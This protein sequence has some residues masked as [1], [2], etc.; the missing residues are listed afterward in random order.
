M[1]DE[2][3]EQGRIPS[4]LTDWVGQHGAPPDAGRD[5][6]PR[7]A[8]YARRS[9]ADPS[10]VSI[11]RQ[12]SAGLDHCRQI[13][14]SIDAEHH[15]YIDRNRSGRTT[16]GRLSLHALL[17]A[18]RDR[19]FD[20]LVVQGLERLTRSMADAV[21]IQAELE[22]LGIAIHVPG[23]GPISAGE[24]LLS[25]FQHQKELDALVERINDGRRRTARSGSMI[26]RRVPYGYDRL[27]DGSGLIVNTEQAS[28]IR[29]CFE[30]IDGGVSRC[31][32]VRTLKAEF[33]L[34]P[35]GRPWQLEQFYKPDGYGRLQDPI[36]KG[37]WTW[38]RGSSNSVTVEV[39]HL[40]IVDAELFDRVNAKLRASGAKSWRTGIKAGLL[41]GLVRCMCGRPMVQ[42]RNRIACS[43]SPHMDRCTAGTAIPLIDAERQYY[44]FLLDEVLD[45][46]HFAD[47][48]AVRAAN[49]SEMQQAAACESSRMKGRL[50]EIT[51]E[52]NAFDDEVGDDQILSAIAGPL[53]VEFHDLW[54]RRERLSSLQALRI[55]RTEADELRSIISRMIVRV[56]YKP[57]DPQEV[58]AVA[59]MHELVPRIVVERRGESIVLRFLL[60]V[61]V[62]GT[63][64]ELPQIG[65]DRWIERPCPRTRRGAMRRPEAI[66]R[67]HRDAEAGR[68]AFTD[69]EWATV[70]D[71]F[72][73]IG[74]VNGGHRLYAEA[75]IFVA[76]TGVPADML[77]E[78]YARSRLDMAPIRKSGIWPRLLAALDASGSDLVRDINRDRFAARHR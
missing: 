47:W 69:R 74:R 58:A 19:L 16:S 77:P 37:V 50:D 24:I 43:R 2:S 46:A 66:I 49:F 29:R 56:P 76:R 59:R 67:H 51:C 60:G 34:G 42:G 44:R 54:E 8:I 62:A 64:K 26:G 53:E 35:G 75:M 9:T 38:A 52:L 14:A 41:T 18:A 72:V 55:D 22:G 25:S 61:L 65:S 39:P 11:T 70:A 20:I 7:A 36:Y 57:T 48:Q 17:A 73:P 12:I 23:R 27:A 30:S 10:F 4:F 32:L 28:V 13:G 3:F 63:E 1:Y 78:R 15:I 68:F 33:V 5:G 31:Q 71:L 21:A 45:P 40:A 6:P